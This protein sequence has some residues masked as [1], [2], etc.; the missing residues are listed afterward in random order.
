MAKKRAAATKKAPKRSPAKK[1]TGRKKAAPK[2]SAGRKAA[3]KK[4]ARK[5][6]PR[7]NEQVT[8]ESN[9]L[10]GLLKR[11]GLKKD[12]RDKARKRLKTLGNLLKYYNKRAKEK[13]EN[14]GKSSQ[15]GKKT[16]KTSSTRSKK[17]SAKGRTT[18]APGRKKVVKK[19]RRK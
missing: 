7:A 4:A 6:G 10:R 16:S 13:A 1:A 8:R 15:D 2:K 5:K 11:K 17:G 14:R 19:G 12:T 18:K 9:R 3:P